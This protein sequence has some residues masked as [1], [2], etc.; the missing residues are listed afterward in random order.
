MTHCV[1]SSGKVAV[2]PGASRE[3]NIGQAIARKCLSEGA[4][5]VVSGR[6]HLELERFACR[7]WLRK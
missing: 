2:V 6:Y 1:R 4:Q 3:G 5:A 7:P